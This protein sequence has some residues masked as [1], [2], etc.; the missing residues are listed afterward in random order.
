MLTKHFNL[1]N[2]AEAFPLLEN[3]FQCGMYRH[4][5]IKNESHWSKGVYT[6]FGFEPNAVESKFENFA[7]YIVEE[8]RD[9]VAEEIQKS[10]TTFTPYKIEFS[11]VDA[12]GIYKRLYAEN[13]FSPHTTEPEEYEGIVKDI[14]ESYFYKKALEEKITQLDKSNQNL[15]EFAYVASHDLHEPLRKISTFT[16][17]LSA[18]FTDQ[19]GEE[20]NMYVKRIISSAANMQT[21]L[22]DLLNYSRLSSTGLKQ[23]KVSLQNCFDC[24][25]ADLEVKIDETK[26]LIAC[27]ELPHIT[28]YASQLKQLFGNLLSNAI[29]FKKKDLPP[30]VKITCSEVTH[31]KF[32]SLPLKK[33]TTYYQVDVEDNGIG[34][35]QE[36]SERIF[37]MFQRLNAK[38]EYS[39]SG[40]GLSICKKIVEN[41]NGFIFANGTSGK[42]AIFT[43]LLPA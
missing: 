41:H 42:G 21:L 37:L 2:L 38:A 18:R 8:D 22:E 12:K 36:F 1:D 5:F 43:L 24:A 11:I 10:R 25:M 32:P 14:S 13:V 27:E 4:N 9:R 6:I 39:G 23:E 3:F 28:G 19:L 20:G 31:V 7:T 29:K 17:R 26:A 16:G 34:F 35:E 30:V 40:I 33:N 15:R